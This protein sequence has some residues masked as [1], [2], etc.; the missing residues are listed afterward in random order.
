MK[1]LRI[2][3]IMATLACVAL[4]SCNEE[5]PDVTLNEDEMVAPVVSSPA[6]GFSKVITAADTT[7]EFTVSWSEAEY[8][9]DLAVN[10]NVQ[11]D[12]AGNEFAGFV[13]VGTST[14]T[15]LTVTFG[16]LNNLLIGNL[17]Q[18]ADEQVSV[19][20]RVVASAAGQAELSSEAV[21]MSITTFE[22]EEE[23]EPVD[24]PKLWVAGD[25]QGWDIANAAIIASTQDNGIYEG[26]LYLPEGG[27]NEFKLY[28]QPDWGPDSYGTLADSVITKANYAGANLIAPSAGYY[29]VSVNMNDSTFFLMDTDWGLIG[30]AAPN[31]WESSTDMTFDESTQTWSITTDLTVGALKFRANN[32]WVLD[33]GIDAEADLI[34]ANHPAMDYVDRTA[35]S[36]AEEGNY[37]ITLDLSDAQNYTYTIVKN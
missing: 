31:G 3:T 29:L 24:Y 34:Y 10:Y 17:E 16:A 36:I 33:F 30:D 8:G 22:A 7:G 32:A 19:A 20:L 28:A 35:I 6:D 2:L 23:E 18:N 25:F 9:V 4:I 26:Y 12:I 1:N 14:E 15:S 27:T 11:I 21:T 37:T 13:S 5:E